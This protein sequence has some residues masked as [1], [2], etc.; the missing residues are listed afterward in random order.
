MSGAT[1]NLRGLDPRAPMPRAE[2]NRVGPG[3][4]PSLG[5]HTDAA[6]RTVHMPL[7]DD[8]G[9][10]AMVTPP[11]PPVTPLSEE[12]LRECLAVATSAKTEALAA[13]E[14][15]RAAH[16][17]AAALVAGRQAIL[18][19]FDDVDDEAETTTIAALKAAAAT[20]LSPTLR[21]RM[22]DREVA[23]ADLIAAERAME[24]L[25]RELAAARTA[26]D[27]AEKAQVRAVDAVL[28]REAGKIATEY[29]RLRAEAARQRDRLIAFDRFTSPREGQIPA[30]VREIILASPMPGGIVDK[31]GW[32]AAATALV[33]DHRAEFSIHA[34]AAPY[35]PQPL[36][37]GR[38]EDHGGKPPR[39]G[40]PAIPIRP[41]VTT[42]TE[43]TD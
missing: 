19:G 23:R 27:E 13:H 28:S 37:P 34:P 29:D 11:A 40:V 4:D 9:L 18:A 10:P 5:G 6:D 38:F 21:T 35:V 8:V 26:A 36:S 3:W 22:V 33:A 31:S 15:A 2:V 12:A 42:E 20:I 41:I 24:S 16:D 1:T 14:A 17:R 30:Q 25:A 43:P 7:R 32:E 39:L